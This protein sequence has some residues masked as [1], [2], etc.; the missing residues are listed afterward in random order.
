MASDEFATS[1]DVLAT[2]KSVAL[3]PRL[4]HHS[5]SF[6]TIYEAGDHR[7]R[8]TGEFFIDYAAY[9]G[10]TKKVPRKI[11]D[12]LESCGKIVRAFP[13]QTVPAWVLAEDLEHTS[14]SEPTQ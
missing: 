5:H 14:K 7:G 9:G 11:I 1:E 10:S 8:G 12:E 6:R 4:K 3:V 2:M 13:D